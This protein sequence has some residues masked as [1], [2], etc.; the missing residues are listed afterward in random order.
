MFDRSYERTDV[1]FFSDFSADVINLTAA[2]FSL[3]IKS[4]GQLPLCFINIFG[5]YILSS[6]SVKKGCRRA[7]A[8]DI[9]NYGYF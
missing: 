2:S 7:S 3:E 6:A 9:L 8:A 5:M 1:S 4:I